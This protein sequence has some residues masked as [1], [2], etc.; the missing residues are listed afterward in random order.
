LEPK[1]LKMKFNDEHKALYDTVKNFALNEIKPYAAEWEKNEK[2][3]AHELF[4]KMGD[5]DL[6]GITKNQE[7]GGM[8]LDYSYGM[9]FAEALGYGLDSGVII[10]TGVQTDMA[11]PALDRFGSKE[12]KNEF[13]TPAISGEYVTSIAVSEHSGGSD[14]AALKTFAK[15]DADDYI[16]KGQKMWIT[17]ATQADYFCTL[18]NTSNDP[19]HKNK[20]L[21]IIPAK[22]PGVEIGEKIDKLG[23]RTSDTAPVYFDDVR[24][25][26]RYRIGEE[27][28]GFSIQMQQFQEERIFL[29][30]SSLIILDDCIKQTIDYCKERNAF[31]KKIID[32]QVIQ[33]RLAELKTEIEALRSLIYR[34]CEEFVDGKDMTYLAS[35]AKLKCGRL[36][37]EVSDSCL[38]YWGG[39]GFTWENP[40]SKIYRDGRLMSIGGGTDEIMLSI[41]CKHIGIGKK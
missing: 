29:S 40:L 25:P 10:S 3:P 5:L 20:S 4:K 16:I 9:V 30:V 14:V 17:N 1:G 24:I 21:V 37:R 31:Q 33:F 32:N 8:G 2:F 11:T 6:L 41:I 36:I 22:L 35:M 26:K 15:S 19:P 34:A 38:Q 28:E 7:N 39:M 18:V 13:L 23:L 27:G 12:L